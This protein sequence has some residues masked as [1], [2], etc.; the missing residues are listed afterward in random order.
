MKMNKIGLAFVLGFGISACG[1]SDTT[2]GAD[3][4]AVYKMDA[5]TPDVV[6]V[7]APVYTWIAIQ[8]VER[9]E[10]AAF[11]CGATNGP[12]ADIDAVALVRGGLAVGYGMKTSANY[13]P[14]LAAESC[15]NTECSGANCKYASISTKFSPAVLAARTEGLPDAI[16][17]K[18]TDDEGYMSL[19]AGLLQIQIG[20]TVGGGTVGQQIQSGDQIMVYEVDQNYKSDTNGCVCTPEHYEVWIQGDTTVTPV[21][22][23]P[24]QYN[25]ANA[26]TCGAAPTALDTLGCGTTTFLVP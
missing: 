13:A 8:D 22:L 16:V 9:S 26:A 5:A 23:M 14:G 25:A 3:A 21:Q 6:A 1:S 12:G 20:D 7:A 19:N 10:T 15:A 4:A 2:T 11:T 24:A 18:S 17:N